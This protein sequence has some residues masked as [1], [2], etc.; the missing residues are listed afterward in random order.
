MEDVLALYEKP[1]SEKEPVDCMDEKPVVL[2]ADVRRPD[3]AV[4][5][6]AG[7]YSQKELEL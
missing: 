2:H 1:L 7:Q 3:Y 5:D 6:L 4:R